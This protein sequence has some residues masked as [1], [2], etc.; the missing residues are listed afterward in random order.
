MAGQPPGRR[1][2]VIT[3]HQALGSSESRDQF[4]L[5]QGQMD[6]G[7]SQALVGSRH[8]NEQSQSAKRRRAGEGEDEWREVPP[9]VEGSL[10][11]RP[12]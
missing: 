2:S 3:S 12:R 7:S 8:R 5:R 1:G 6:G 4:Y 9:P 11:P 10:G